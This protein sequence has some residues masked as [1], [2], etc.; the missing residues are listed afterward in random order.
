[1][2]DLL[3]IYVVYDDPTDYPGKFVI[4]RNEIGRGDSEISPALSPPIV[5]VLAEPDL[6]CDTYEQAVHWLL[7]RPGGLIRMDRHPTDPPQIKEVWI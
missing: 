3:E 7:R 6:V 5:R 1:M 4:R 2:R